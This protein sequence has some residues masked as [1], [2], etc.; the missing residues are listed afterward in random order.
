MQGRID[1]SRITLARRLQALSKA[2]LA[3]RTGVS[4]G[5]VV[6]WEDGTRDATSRVASLSDALK[7]PEKFFFG[8]PVPVSGIESVSFRKRYDATRQLK[9]RATAAIDASA[10]VLTPALSEFFD[11]PLPDVDVPN[12]SGLSPEAAART[13]RSHWGLSDGPLRSVVAQLEARGVRLSWV[14]EP[15]PSL[16]AFCKWIDKQPYMVLNNDRRD[17]CRAR[18]NAAHEL[19]HLVLDQD[20]NYEAVELKQSEKRTDAFASAFLMPKEAFLED[21]PRVFD[22]DRLFEVKRVWKVSIQAIVHRLYDLDIFTDWQ[23]EQAFRIMSAKGWRRGPEPLSGQVEIS[24]IHWTL[25]DRLESRDLTAQDWVSQIGLHWESASEMMPV[26]MMRQHRLS[27][28]SVLDDPVGLSSISGSDH[29]E[30]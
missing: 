24:K 1:P 5:T 17:G 11:K 12:L 25:C 28:Q 15:S 21:A 3:A 9:D 26:L 27:I 6:F 30:D 10:G 23:Y 29:Y 22:L 20:T 14:S 16:S 7:Q 13:L 8:S 19:G 2:E 4:P 18:F